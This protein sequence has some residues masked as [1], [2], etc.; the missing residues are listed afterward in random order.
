MPRPSRP[1]AAQSVMSASEVPRPTPSIRKNDAASSKSP[2][3]TM[4]LAATRS[5]SR[6]AIG[7]VT[8]RTSPAGSSTAPACDGGRWSASCMKTGTRYVEPNSAMP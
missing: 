8:A 2:T 1:I 5:A 3:L 6:P 4:R 7:I